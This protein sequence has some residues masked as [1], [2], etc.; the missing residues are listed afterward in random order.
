VAVNCGVNSSRPDFAC[1]KDLATADSAPDLD[2]ADLF[3]WDGMR[4]S[5]EDDIVRELT[6]LDTSDGR[7][8][9]FHETTYTEVFLAADSF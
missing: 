6:C 8:Y 2:V 3:L 4:I 9:S 1:W 5:F 7:Q